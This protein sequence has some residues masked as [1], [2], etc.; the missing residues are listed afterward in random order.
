MTKAVFFDRDGVINRSIVR[1]G[2]PYPPDDAR[3][4]EWMDGV[5]EALP[6]L[7]TR[8][9]LL[10]VFTN[11]PDVARGT[12]SRAVVD[13]FHARI[14]RE[15]PFT[16]IYTCFHDDAD[17]CDCRKPKPGMIFRGRDEYGIDLAASWVVGDRWRDIDAG[18]AA[19]CKTIY[20]D[21]AYTETPPRDYD[22]KIKHMSELLTWIT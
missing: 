10:F 22:H 19:G 2:R 14:E 8:G 16:R 5:H 17:G 4:F 13:A 20:I 21:H 6:L 12:Q 1:A 18:R 11:Q 15:L 3:Q 7:R 9:Y